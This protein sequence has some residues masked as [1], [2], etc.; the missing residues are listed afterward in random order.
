MLSAGKLQELCRERQ[1]D[2]GQLAERLAGAK[3]NKK[4]AVAAVKNWQKGLFKPKPRADDIRRLATALSVEVNDIADWRSSYRFAPMSARKARLVTQ[5]IVGR[6]V[7]NAMDLLKF[8]RKRAATM[9][10][11]VLRSAVADADEQQVNVDNLYVSSARVDDAGIRI[12]T[13]RWIPK[14]RGKA[15]PIRKKACHIHIT[16]AQI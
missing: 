7:Q 4:Q 11:K 9:I 15:H 8:T 14:D 16:V 5:L 2:I 12:G 1:M 3:L 13:K 6:S 10:D